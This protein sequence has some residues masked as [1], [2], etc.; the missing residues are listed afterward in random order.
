M[1]IVAAE[2][3]NLFIG[4]EAS[5]RQVALVA[6]RGSETSSGEPGRV[7]IRGA[8][9]RTEEAVSVGDLVRLLRLQRGQIALIEVKLPSESPNADHPLYELRLPQ[10]SAIVAIIREGHVVIPV[11]ETVLASEDEILALAS[12]EAEHAFIEAVVGGA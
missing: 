6:V 9:L 8:G 11:P 7:T 2:S 10:D 1:D 12:P 5:P 3:T 4:T